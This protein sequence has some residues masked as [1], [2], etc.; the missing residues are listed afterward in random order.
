MSKSFVVAFYEIDRCYGG[1]EEGGWWFDT[2]ELV[3]TVKVFH[4]EDDAFAWARAANYW[5]R[6]FQR[7]VRSVGSV[8]Y[9]GGRY[10]ARVFENTAPQRYP[11]YRPHYE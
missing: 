8:I 4:N 1:P 10:E 3:R 11:E 6:F 5:L 9:D 7:N 2:G